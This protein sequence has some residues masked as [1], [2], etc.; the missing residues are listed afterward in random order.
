M[1]ARRL[2]KTWRRWLRTSV[3]GLCVLVL[4]IGAGLGWVVH[5]AHD[6]RDAVA[7]IKGVGGSVFYDWQ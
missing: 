6:Q 1:S 5:Q 4:A 7:A 2:P 3:R